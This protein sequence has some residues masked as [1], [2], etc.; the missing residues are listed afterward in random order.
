MAGNAEAVLKAMK[1]AAEP[2][3]PGDIA[4]MTGLS[5][6]DVGKAINEL[7]KAGKISSP[8]RCF[9]EPA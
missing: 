5:K 2:V 6:D 3:R 9:W 4:E 8:R 7:K 1:K